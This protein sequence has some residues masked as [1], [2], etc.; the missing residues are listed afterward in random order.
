MLLWAAGATNVAAQEWITRQ[1]DRLQ[2]GN[3]PFYFSGVNAYYLMQAAMR[4]DT[5]TVAAVFSSARAL[6]CRVVRTWAFSDGTDSTNPSLLQFAPGKYN[7]HALQAL[8][9]V[10]ASA[11]RSGLRLILPLVNNWD[12]YGGMNQ[13][14]RWRAGTGVPSSTARAQYPAQDSVVSG[15]LGR[16]YH[17]VP[18]AQFLHD[19]FYQDGIIRQWYRAHLAFIVS[20]T[21]TRTGRVYRDEPTIMGWELA[22]EPRSSDHSGEMVRAWVAEMA[23]FLKSMDARH[24]V[25]TGEE[26]FETSAAGY[27]ASAFAG[28]SWLFDG[29][30]GVS[31]TKNS[32]TDALDF[33]SIHLYPDAW[34][35]PYGAGNDW[36]RDHLTRSREL[37]KPVILGEFGALHD[38]V[39][40]YN[41]WFSTAVNDGAGGAMVWQLLEGEW[42][43]P[44]GYGFRIS[45]E[46]GNTIRSAS[47]FFQEKSL[48]GRVTPPAKFLLLRN[49]PNPFNGR[50]TIMYDLPAD[51]WVRLEVYD[52]RGARVRTLVDDMQNA[53][54]RNELFDGRGLAS[55]WY[56]FTLVVDLVDGG[57]IT[58]S[59]SPMVYVR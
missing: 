27:R 32:S 9:I 1:G 38:R 35:L 52:A 7:E 36:I 22:N 11:E 23:R 10:I 37:G 30:S 56:C 50:T 12:A 41:S 53:G 46:V 15:A 2:E 55:G 34:N 3:H 19:D 33:T 13:Y 26:G 43:D 29:T 18:V 6:G 45:G 51:A 49:F 54:T 48:T 21:N 16:T 4:G 42:T 44:E 5:E 28:Q 24:L 57:R 58:T 14:V 31:F 59:S 40:T 25:G 20:R 17:T 8:D 47:A 39:L